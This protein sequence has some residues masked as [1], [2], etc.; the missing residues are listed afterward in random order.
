MNTKE[1]FEIKEI[2]NI[3]DEYVND[4]YFFDHKKSLTKSL[5]KIQNNYNHTF[6]DDTNQCLCENTDDNCFGNCDCNCGICIFLNN[7]NNNYFDFTDDS[8]LE[9]LYYESE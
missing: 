1:I 5:I 3:I 4:L 7:Y 8:E 2:K 6:L 9:E